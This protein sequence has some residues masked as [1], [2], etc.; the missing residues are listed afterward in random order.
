WA[1]KSL[2][3]L[4][5]AASIP[6]LTEKVKTDEKNRVR[7]AAAD[8][9]GAL[10]PEGIE[11]LLKEIAENDEDEG[12]RKSAHEAV[13]SLGFDAEDAEFDPFAE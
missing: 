11:E 4:G 5:K 13:L 8:A 12:V 1:A 3:D 2:G 6:V 10:R 9:L 7:A